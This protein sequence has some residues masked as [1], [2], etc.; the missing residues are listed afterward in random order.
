[1]SITEDRL[2]TSTELKGDDLANREYCVGITQFN[3]KTIRKEVQ[4]GYKLDTGCVKA[5]TAGSG[6]KLGDGCGRRCEKQL[7][8]G[9]KTESPQGQQRGGI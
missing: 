8:A 5:G 4:T 6:S 9:R 7:V 2:P 1:M 3:T